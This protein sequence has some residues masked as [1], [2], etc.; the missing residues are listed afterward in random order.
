MAAAQHHQTF[1]LWYLTEDFR[2]CTLYQP[3]VGTETFAAVSGLM[4][5]G[6]L[7]ILL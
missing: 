1:V 6:W 7:A 4:M 5:E 2:G 3:G